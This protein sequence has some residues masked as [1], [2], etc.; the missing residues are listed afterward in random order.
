MLQAQDGTFYGTFSTNTSGGII[1]FDQS[2]NIQWTV[3]NDSPQ[4][5]TADGGVIGSSGITYDNQ[6]RATGQVSTPIQSWSGEA[7]YQYGSVEDV[8]YIHFPPATP[9]Y[10]SFIGSNQSAN[11]TSPLC[12]DDRDQFMPEYVTFGAD[13]VPSCQKFK[14]AETYGHNEVFSF[15]VMNYSDIKRNDHPNWALL[16]SSM[17]SAIQVIS[18]DYDSSLTVDSA[19]RSPFVQYEVTKETCAQNNEVPCHQHPRDRHIHGDAVDFNTYNDPDIWWGLYYVVRYTVSPNACIEP[20]N[21][22]YD[23]I[24]V[25]WRPWPQCSEAWQKKLQQP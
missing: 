1:K 7:A 18:A 15:S 23:H 8:I 22:K 4:I 3:L 11:K 21:S 5:A 6:G 25:D 12:H 19:Y 24:H 2:G 9:P 14:D 17:L 10:S 16:E 13:F 20:H